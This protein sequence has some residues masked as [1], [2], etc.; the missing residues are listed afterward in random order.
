MTA[1]KL[2]TCVC[3]S[4]GGSNAAAMLELVSSLAVMIQN[5]QA[6]LP[7]SDGAVLENNHIA[8]PAGGLFDQVNSHD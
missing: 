4:L 3:M 1:K 2:A 7:E 8:A 6:V 5:H